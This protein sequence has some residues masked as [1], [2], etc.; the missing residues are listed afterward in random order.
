[1]ELRTCFNAKLPLSEVLLIR[2]QSLFLKGTRYGSQNGLVFVE[3][4]VYYI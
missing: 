4:I 3:L 2:T 1:M